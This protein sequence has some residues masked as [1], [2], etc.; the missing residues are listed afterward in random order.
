MAV[1]FRR[2]VS[3]MSPLE[4]LASFSRPVVVASHSPRLPM[5][6]RQK[7]T[8]RATLYVLQ[9]LAFVSHSGAFVPAA[10]RIRALGGRTLRAVP[11]QRDG[12]R[13]A[14]EQAS[15][16]RQEAA[17]LEKELEKGV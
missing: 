17:D 15:R 4:P 12:A 9:L 7:R 5:R 3:I 11:D 2:F 6:L 10:G 14:L 8:M 1:E 16:L 13:K